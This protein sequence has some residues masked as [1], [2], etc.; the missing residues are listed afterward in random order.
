VGVGNHCWQQP[1]RSRVPEAPRPWWLLLVQR[2]Q[3]CPRDGGCRH[4]RAALRCS[5]WG[6]AMKAPARSDIH[7]LAQHA[8]RAGALRLP[9]LPQTLAR[10]P[11]APIPKAGLPPVSSPCWRNMNCRSATCAASS[12]SKNRGANSRP[13]RTL[14]N[15]DFKGHCQ[16]CH[17]PRVEPWRQAMAGRRRQR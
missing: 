3:H 14:A 1:R 11:P 5:P 6:N 8:D 10:L 9:Q 7:T 12:V 13:A 4:S 17:V 16:P 2:P 15:F